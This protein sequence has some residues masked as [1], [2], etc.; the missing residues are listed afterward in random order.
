MTAAKALKHAEVNITDALVLLSRL[1]VQRAA[2]VVPPT[3]LLA[4]IIAATAAAAT[5]A[6]FIA[7][8]GG[9]VLYATKQAVTQSYCSAPVGLYS[10]GAPVQALTSGGVD[11][12]AIWASHSVRLGAQRAAKGWW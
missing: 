6:V 10:A 9:M 1:T 8:Y 5:M 4:Q 3:S 2:H 11:G 12:T 7:L